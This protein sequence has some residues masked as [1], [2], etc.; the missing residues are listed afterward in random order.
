MADAVTECALW[1]FE[2]VPSIQSGKN[3][4]LYF[5]TDPENQEQ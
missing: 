1:A 4:I 5:V 2:K 3:Q